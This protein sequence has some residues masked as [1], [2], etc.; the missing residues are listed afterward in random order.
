M[1]LCVSVCIC[2]DLNRDVSLPASL[3]TSLFVV[4]FADVNHHV[5]F[6]C[7]LFLHHR[8]RNTEIKRVMCGGILMA[9]MMFVLLLTSQWELHAVVIS[10]LIITQLFPQIVGHFLSCKIAVITK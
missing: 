7:D 6:V 3:P 2:V 10:L 1:S 8:R 5:S 4:C 9:N